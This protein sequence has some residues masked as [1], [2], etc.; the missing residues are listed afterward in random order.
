MIGRWGEGEEGGVEGGDT[1][2]DGKTIIKL[3]HLSKHTFHITYFLTC[4][5][6]CT[7]HMRQE[8]EC[9]CAEMDLKT[10]GTA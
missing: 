3:A 8:A 2:I 6:K 7:T 10:S 4:L 1:E 5:F 9:P